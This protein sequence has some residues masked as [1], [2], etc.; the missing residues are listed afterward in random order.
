M[1]CK[2]NLFRLPTEITYLNCAYMSP[3][4]RSL[5]KIGH[6]AVSQKTQ[7]FSIKPADFFSGPAALKT[8]F[9]KLVNCPDSEQIAIIPA[10]S[11]GVA[12]V[13]KNLPRRPGGNLVVVENEFPSDIYSIRKWAAENGCQIRT[14]GPGNGP[15]RGKI[16]NQNLLEAIDSQTVMVATGHVHWADGTRFDLQKIGEKCRKKG[17]WLVVDGIQSVGALPFDVAEIRPDALIVGGYKWML[18]PYSI[19]CAFYSER[20]L[21][22]GQPIEENWIHRAVSEDFRSLIN[23][24]DDYQ[25]GMNR[26]SMGGFSQFFNEPIMTAAIHQLLEW[27]PENIQNYARRISRKPLE[28]LE[29]MGCQL[30]NPRFRANHLVGVRIPAGLFS[31]EKLERALAERQIF[32]SFRGDAMRVSIHLWND[33]A[34]LWRLIECFEAAKN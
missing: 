1:R 30:E 22:T 31:I 10:V 17:A 3:L 33:E 29:K 12:T 34:D 11:Y 20:M 21:E 24:R 5:E 7:P 8:A 19:G 32:V 28:A 16:W 23:Y 14:V 9:S 13:V 18:G 27:G 6:Q 25:P 4:M 26:F 15:E 2:R